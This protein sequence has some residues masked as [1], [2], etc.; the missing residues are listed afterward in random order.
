MSDL[1]LILEI[2]TLIIVSVLANKVSDKFGI[3]S[4][5]IFLFIGMLA[6]S[7][8]PGKIYFANHQFAE[9]LGTIALSLILFYG[10]LDTNIKKI[11]PV[12]W[13]GI[14]L[15][16]A[17]VLITAVILAVL[18]MIFLK[19]SLAQGL[20]V[21]AIVS[22]TDAAA[23]FSVLR[24]RNV[25]LKGN[26]KPLLELESGVNDPMAVFLT[27]AMVSY[28]KFKTSIG[29]LIPDYC[30]QMAVGIIIGFIVAKV[31]IFSINKIRLEQE[32]L[33]PVLAMAFVIFDYAL[34]AAFHG[35]GFLAVYITGIIVGNSE[36][37]HKKSLVQFHA[38]LA[39]LMQITMFL[40]LGLLIVP[41]EIVPIIGTGLLLS[42]FL[43]LFAR[44]ISVFIC[45][46]GS[47]F[48]FR[49]QLMV[50]WVGLR[51]A[52]PIILAIFPLTEGV[53]KADVIFNVVFFIVLSSALL[54]GTLLTSVSKFLGVYEPMV[55][56][57]HYPIEFE[58]MPGMN[59]ELNE[60]FIPFESEIAGKPLFEIGVPKEA[61]VTLVSREDKFI[62][63]NGSTVIEGGDVLLVLSNKDDLKSV[64]NRVNKIRARIEVEK[65]DN[66]NA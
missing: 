66:Q 1:F 4:L 43:M 42:L 6:G 46:L 51:G 37:L 7:E 23:V 44:P 47:K 5:L 11:R 25:S 59:A 45:L 58:N 2:S 48:N 64:E 18:S 54:Q 56:K 28:I 62:I 41:S 30:L 50:S 12:L 34:A 61:L 19:F 10:G 3:P 32:G 24:S 35:S 15:A 21:G 13:R 20:L 38:G 26:V 39:W 8:G 49:E 16:T 40:T 31:M 14:S 63:P 53:P 55:N 60:V 9:S 57:P 22:S 17:G 52:V 33:Y 36:F 65:E 27:V 29:M